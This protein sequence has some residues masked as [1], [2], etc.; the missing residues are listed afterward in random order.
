[1][2]V[3][4]YP[5]SFDPIT[6]GHMDVILRSAAVFDKV[7]VAVL[8]NVDK[9]GLFSI[10]ERVE[11]IRKLV[12]KYDNIEV[13][14]F[15]GLLVDFMESIG[16]H[17]II[18]GLRVGL[19]FDYELQ[20]AH[21]NRK[22]SKEKVETVLMMASTEY[23]YISSSS[24]REILHFKGDIRG[25]VPDEIVHDIYEKV[26]IVMEGTWNERKL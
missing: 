17:I 26:G 14:S 7:I 24:V 13:V 18:K 19:D 5:G 8:K 2:R 25:F 20:M 16:A 22:L 6:L 4:V 3:A 9:K 11:M 12:R 23:S 1:M 15:Q 10:D 21:M